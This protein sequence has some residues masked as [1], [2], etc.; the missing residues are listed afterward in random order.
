MLMYN[1]ITRINIQL[2]AY[3]VRYFTGLNLVD[4]YYDFASRNHFRRYPTA[5]G[6]PGCHNDSK[7][8]SILRT[9]LG[10]VDKMEADPW[11]IVSPRGDPGIPQRTT[12]EEAEIS[13]GA[14]RNFFLRLLIN[15]RIIFN[16][17]LRLTLEISE[18]NTRNRYTQT[19]NYVFRELP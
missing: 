6:A 11:N 13:K 14:L 9:T 2:G 19:S 10:E 5:D 3:R 7:K 18:D 12:P 15:L 8:E 16:V 4:Q 1:G 17:F